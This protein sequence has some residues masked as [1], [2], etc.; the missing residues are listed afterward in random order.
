MVGKVVGRGGN[1]SFGIEGMAGM[2][3]SGG[4]V[5]LGKDGNVDCGIVGRDGKGG[6]VGLGRVGSDEGK[7]GNVGFGRL[8]IT[9]V[10][11]TEGE[12]VSKRRRAARLTSML[13]NDSKAVERKDLYL[14]TQTFTEGTPFR[15]QAPESNFRE[16]SR[17]ISQE[18]N[19]VCEISQTP[20]RAAK[21][22]R[23]TELSSQGCEVGFHLEVPSSLLAAWFVYRQKEKHF[24]VQ[25][26]C[27]ITLQQKGDFATLCKM[28]PS[29]RSDWLVMAATSSFQL[30]IAH[31]L[32][33][34]I[35]DFLSFEMTEADV[36]INEEI[37]G[38]SN[39][40]CT[41][42]NKRHGIENNQNENECVPGPPVTN[43]LS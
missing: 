3:G 13:E 26:C 27:E 31:H 11:G 15:E 25:K 5:A 33:H 29:A 22:F 14:L 38:Y 4:S 23:N 34:W 18:K 7:G 2:L 32:K 6:N 9:G 42:E 17:T 40:T 35:I 28:L 20:K 12:A 10:V 37:S 43:A 39:Q 24:T 21:L 16:A 8:G 1:V 30:R 36:A 41:Y 19:G